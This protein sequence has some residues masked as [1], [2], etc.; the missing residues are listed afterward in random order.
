MEG[1]HLSVAISEKTRGHGVVGDRKGQGYGSQDE[2][3]PNGEN[4]HPS[5][6]L[7][8][9]GA[10]ASRSMRSHRPH[11]VRKMVGYLPN[12][13]ETDEKGLSNDGKTTEADTGLE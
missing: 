7:D 1:F 4:M 6:L 11:G 5:P 9:R 10:T 13:P 2:N 12:M 8:E 3:G